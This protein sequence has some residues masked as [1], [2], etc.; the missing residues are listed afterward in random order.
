MSLLAWNCR[1]LGKPRTVQ[2]LKEIVQQLKPSLIF[3][4]ETLAKKDRVDKIC[5]ALNFAGCWVVDV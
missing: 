5:K 2:F 3:L 1:G 4:S